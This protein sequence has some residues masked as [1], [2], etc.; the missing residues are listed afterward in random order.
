MEPIKASREDEDMIK[1]A[2]GKFKKN[3]KTIWRLDEVNFEFKLNSRASL[4]STTHRFEAWEVRNLMLQTMHGSKLE[5]NS[6]SQLKY[7]IKK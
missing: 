6:Y 1:L 7:A 2:W 5:W 4:W 3:R